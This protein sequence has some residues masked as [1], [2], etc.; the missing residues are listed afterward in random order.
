VEGQ[1]HGGVAHGLGN[2]LLEEAVYDEDGQ[3]LTTTYLDYLL[4]TSMDVPSVR[5][6]HQ[7]FPS[8]RN[9]LGVKGV[10]EGGAVAAPAAIVNA[11]EDA[12][13]PSPVRITRIPVAP[14]RI[15]DA[16]SA[17]GGAATD[18]ATQEVLHVVEA[19]DGREQRGE[20]R[21]ARRLVR[22][23]AVARDAGNQGLHVF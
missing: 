19:H 16:I 12:I 6:G 17:V 22:L 14:E 9:P 7:A 13:W 21:I 18:R 8:D 23:P 11:I 10:G 1:V 20:D 2:A 4:P 3:L 15:V 5:V